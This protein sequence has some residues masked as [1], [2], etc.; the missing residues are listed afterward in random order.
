[1]CLCVEIGGVRWRRMRIAG[2][3]FYLAILL[4]LPPLLGIT[5]EIR[6]PKV[7]FDC[8]GCLGQICLRHIS[9]PSL[10]QFK[11]ASTR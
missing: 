11:A 8:C 9:Q 2:L 3:C 4:S 5:G 7:S 10:L 6:I 1:M